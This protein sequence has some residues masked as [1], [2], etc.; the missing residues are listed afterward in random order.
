M[1]GTARGVLAHTYISRSVHA[2]RLNGITVGETGFNAAIAGHFGV[3]VALVCGDDTVDAEVDELLPSAERV[4]TK[5]AL[6]PFA[7][8]NLTPKA[9]QKHIQEGAK[10][11]LGRLGE[12]KPLVLEKPI[13]FE[14]DF[15]HALYAYVA[16]DV[17]GVE[18]I[19]GRT[20]VYTGTDMLEVTR[21]WRLIIN[22]S[23]G[24]AFV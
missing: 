6:S 19:D 17:P 5:W 11:A 20:L 12:I 15:M 18:W 14:V 1:V 8:C 16:A 22:T 23:L 10:R 9:A 7:A 21:I 4:I 24:E 3:P 2:V 13:R